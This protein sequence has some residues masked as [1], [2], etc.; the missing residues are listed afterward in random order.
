MSEELPKLR[1]KHQFFSLLCQ[2]RN[3]RQ[4]GRPQKEIASKTG[5]GKLNILSKILPVLCLVLFFSVYF[6]ENSL[7]AVSFGDDAGAALEEKNLPVSSTKVKLFKFDPMEKVKTSVDQAR[8]TEEKERQERNAKKKKAVAENAPLDSLELR[9]KELVAGSPLEKMVPFLAK[10]DRETAAYLIAIAKKESDWGQHSP[11]KAGN[12]CFNYWGYRGTYNQTTS[13]Y[14]CFDSPEQAILVVG[15]RIKELLDKK[16][17]TAEKLV[18]W[19]CGSSC[20]G[21]DPAGVRKWIS[22][23]A[24][25][26]KKVNS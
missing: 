10:C 7:T 6:G 23:V 17:N 19:K 25:Y 1:E 13:G 16:I 14:S 2:K 26:Y 24:L 12:D 15:E 5:I 3:N 9:Y 8:K 4:E 20:A 18:V 11:K 22:D 21:H